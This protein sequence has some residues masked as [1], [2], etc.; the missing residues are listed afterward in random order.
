[1]NAKKVSESR[2]IQTSLILP[3]NANYHGSI[4]GG[5]VLS[6]VDEVAS[7][8]AM[9]HCRMPVVTA[10][11]DSF[12]FLAPAKVSN[13][14]QLEAFIASTGRTSMEI[15]V[16]VSSENLLTGRSTLTGVSFVTFVGL[17]AEGKPTPVPAVIPETEEEKRLF[18]SAAERQKVRKD[19]KGS[20]K[21]FI[22]Q[23]DLDKSI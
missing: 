15:I 12:D 3:T 2:T 21:E 11:I 10:S 9:R 7:I 19:R 5:D 1:M 14:L 18:D 16:K 8:T 13:T 23:Y 17:D 4:F 6:M 20:V 22:R